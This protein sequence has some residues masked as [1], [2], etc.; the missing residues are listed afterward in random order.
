MSASKGKPSPQIRGLFAARGISGEA[1]APEVNHTRHLSQSVCGIDPVLDEATR[2]NAGPSSIAV[3]SALGLP[4]LVAQAQTRQA[5]AVGTDYEP[6]TSKNAPDAAV[7]RSA[8]AIAALI[9]Q[10][11]RSAYHATGRPC[12]CPDD[13]TRRRS[14]CGASSAYSRPGGASPKCYPGDVSEREIE[15]L[16]DRL[17]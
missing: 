4:M 15:D 6:S 16:L 11:S 9:V 5:A 8:A 10:Q 3:L 12:A 13:L 1:S 2:P 14:R 7:G 17:K